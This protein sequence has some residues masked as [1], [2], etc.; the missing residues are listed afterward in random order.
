MPHSA[1]DHYMKKLEK[2]QAVLRLMLGEAAKL[3]HMEED[4]RREW[5]NEI[6][7]KLNDGKR[8]T[9]HVPIAVL[10]MIGIGIRK[11]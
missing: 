10:K 2:Q 5:A 4:G 9:K 11:Q 3:P 7:E 1:I 6:T 8:Q